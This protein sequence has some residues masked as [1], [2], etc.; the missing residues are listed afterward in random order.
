[1][2]TV[3]DISHVKDTADRFEP[4]EV[5][6]TEVIDN[7]RRKQTATIINEFGLYNGI[8]LN[9]NGSCKSDMKPR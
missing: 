6:Q 3:L 5:G 7:L 9:R 2:C 4:D 1:M 8:S